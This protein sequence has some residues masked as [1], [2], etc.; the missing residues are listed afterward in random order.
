MY[1]V[2]KSKGYLLALLLCVC[3]FS[4]SSIGF[5]LPQGPRGESGKSAYEI[6]KEEVKAGRIDWPA[7]QVEVTDFLMYIKGEKGDKGADGMS[8][9]EQ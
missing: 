1:T 6:W 9:Y 5:E 2:K 3:F 7:G 8:A 4:C